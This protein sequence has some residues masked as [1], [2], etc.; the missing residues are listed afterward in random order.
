MHTRKSKTIFFVLEGMNSLATS[1]FGSYVFFL[2][3]DRFGFGSLGNLSTAALGGWEE[4]F[5]TLSDPEEKR[6]FQGAQKL[7]A[8][9]LCFFEA[10][11]FVI[12]ARLVMVSNPLPALRMVSA[13]VPVTP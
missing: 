13:P 12:F 6:T 11:V 5:R 7:L 2:L 9:I 10:A 1:Y 3:R 4:V 8:I